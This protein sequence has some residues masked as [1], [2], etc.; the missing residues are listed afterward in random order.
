MFQND[1]TEAA[2]KKV[3]IKVSHSY[4]SIISYTWRW[5]PWQPESRLGLGR[6]VCIWP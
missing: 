5:E 2:S 6:P 1:M 3:E 4:L